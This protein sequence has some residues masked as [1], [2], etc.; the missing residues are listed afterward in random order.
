MLAIAQRPKV[1]IIASSPVLVTD[2]T[3]DGIRGVLESLTLL[4]IKG[5]SNKI[6]Y[7]VDLEIPSIEICL[8]VY[9]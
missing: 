3:G 2:V 7:L 4:I 1:I 9:M 6:S 5:I 8:R